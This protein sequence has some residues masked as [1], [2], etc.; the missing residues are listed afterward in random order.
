MPNGGK[1]LAGSCRRTRSWAIPSFHLGAFATARSHLEQAWCA[2]PTRRS[3]LVH[4][5]ARLAWALWFLGYPDQAVAR[6]EAALAGAREGACPYSL[7]VALG[8]AGSC[9]SGGRAPRRRRLC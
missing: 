7:A 8:H 4:G 6:L 1:I 3:C 5:L 9:T 2:L